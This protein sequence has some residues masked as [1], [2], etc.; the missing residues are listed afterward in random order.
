MNAPLSDADIQ[1]TQAMLAAGVDV[2][3]N[4]DRYESYEETVA[5]IYREMV[6]AASASEEG[7]SGDPVQIVEMR[8][9]ESIGVATG[10]RL[11][12]PEDNIFLDR[13]NLDEQMFGAG[14]VRPIPIPDIIEGTTTAGGVN[15]KPSNE[16][17]CPLRV[18]QGE[19]VI[20]NTWDVFGV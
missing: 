13:P 9:G 4:P 18:G 17:G 20:G 7:S 8:S 1:I 5:R 11:N 10:D 3:S 14:G 2:Y 6:K 15:V 12:G 16:E 19:I